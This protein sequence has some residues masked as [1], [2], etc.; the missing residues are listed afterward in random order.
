MSTFL[1]IH[2]A[3]HGA[4]CWKHV[5]PMLRSAG[6]SVVAPDL[7]GHGDDETPYK[8]V[9]LE[10][11]VMSVCNELDK[12]DDQV[13]LVGH[14]MG[15]IIITETAERRPGKIRALVYLCAFLPQNGECLA[16]MEQRNPQPAVPPN[17]VP[18]K[19]GLTATIPEDKVTDLFYHDCPDADIEYAK[20]HLCP[21]ALGLLN[22]PVTI[23]PEN[24]GRIPR[25]YILC[26]EDR[27]LCLDFQNEMVN[28]SPGT[29]TYSLKSSHS[30][31]F[32]MPEKLVELL[33]EIGNES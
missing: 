21:Q 14:S 15:G 22:T 16:G 32:S 18:T 25:N 1:L 8:Q 2:G 9:N 10:K 20:R 23:T 12:L 33:I 5:V 26:T 6:H 19:N 28:A 17:L 4:W 13:I 7:P 24:Y 30:P 31:F 11:Y 3:W 27:A 29:A